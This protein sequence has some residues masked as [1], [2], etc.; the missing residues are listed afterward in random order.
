MGLLADTHVPEFLDALP[1]AVSDALSGVEAILHAGDV[2]SQAVLDQLAELAPVFAVR[3]DHDREL[4]D[5]PRSRLIQI[6][7]MRIGLIHGEMPFWIEEPRTFLETM[8]LGAVQLEPNRRR[9]ARQ[10]PD[11]DLIVF[12]HYHRPIDRRYGRSRQICPGSVYRL[13][14]LEA[15]RRLGAGPS[16]F[17]WSF[18]QV[19]RR[20][21]APLP[22]ASVALLTISEGDAQV[23]F[24]EL[25]DLRPPQARPR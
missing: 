5:L 21:R 4:A 7:G 15:Q 18:L 19:A 22:S 10:F 3:G 14:A 1:T 25:A 16:W 20:R 17:E 6:A 24:V 13:D 8:A 12:G 11:A 9:L 23:E 2:T